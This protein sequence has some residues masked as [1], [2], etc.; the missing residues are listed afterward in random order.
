VKYWVGNNTWGDTTPE[1]RIVPKNQELQI[2]VEPTTEGEE[3]T[4]KKVASISH[5]YTYICPSC[6]GQ[7]TTKPAICPS[8]EFKEDS[9]KKFAAK[10][11]IIDE[12]KPFHFEAVIP[13]QKAGKFVMFTI[14]CTTEYGIESYCPSSLTNYYSY[15]VQ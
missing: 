4:W 12:G 15:T 5:T 1:L 13:K 9:E 6:S 11:V 3:V 8:C 14:Y 10:D 2:K 7:T